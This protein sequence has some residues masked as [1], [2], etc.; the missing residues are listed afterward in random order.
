MASNPRV[1]VLMS[2]YN[3]EKF[4]REAIDSILDQTFS[5]FEFVIYDD[6]STDS[7]AQIIRSYSDDRIVYRRNEVNVGLTKNLADGVVRARGEY[8]AR[9]DADDISYPDRLSKQVEWMDAHK[10]VSILGSPVVYFDDKGKDV[11]VAQQPIGDEEIKARLFVSFT[12][13]HPTIMIRVADL[14]N[15]NINYNPDY[16]C[17]QDH[18]LYFDCILAGLKFGNYHLP[19]LRMR[20]HNGSISKAQSGKQ[21]ECS[22]L[23]RKSF[24]VRCGVY[25]QFA[26]EKF[27]A[28]NN[29]ASGAMLRTVGEMRCLD[30][31]FLNI[32]ANKELHKYFDKGLVLRD[33]ANLLKSRCYE[34]AIACPKS[35]L[36]YFLLAMSKHADGWDFKTRVKYL[37]KILKGAMV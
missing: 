5:D 3:G 17:S 34:F 10:D 13:M 9:M 14:K 32:L 25:S 29:F 15:N 35:S 28:Y 20:A 2:V 30:S 23:A 18:A 26:D 7:S 6:C 11:G 24:F 4:L 12:L 36:I 31:F 33:A 27:D 8:I 1:T 16:R 21:K 22:R 19:L 37:L